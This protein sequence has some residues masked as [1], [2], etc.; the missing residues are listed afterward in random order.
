MR[1]HFYHK[2]GVSIGTHIDSKRER[3]L[4]SLHNGLGKVIREKYKGK[5]KPITGNSIISDHR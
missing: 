3:G 5:E 4:V 1:L 2:Q